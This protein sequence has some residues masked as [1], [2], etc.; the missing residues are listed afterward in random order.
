MINNFRLVQNLTCMLRTYRICNS[1]VRFS[2]YEFN[3]NLSNG[4][5]LLKIISCVI[6]TQPTLSHT[7]KN[8]NKNKKNRGFEIEIVYSTHD[9][10]FKKVCITECV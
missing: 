9:F 4:I 8:K 7:L 3:K 6:W 10:N 2:K 1:S 5:T